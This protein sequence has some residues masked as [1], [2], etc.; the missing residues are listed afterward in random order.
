[1]LAFVSLLFQWVAYGK[2]ILFRLGWRLAARAPRPVVSI[3]NLSFGGTGKTPTVIA[4]CRALE[5][6]GLKAVVLTRGYRRQKSEETEQVPKAADATRYGDEPAL[7][8]ERI[9]SPVVV[10][11]KRARAALWAMR[12]SPDL[13]VLDDGFSHLQLARDL[14]VVLLAK[15]DMRSV[16][17]RR[18]LRRSLKDADFVCSL[19][20][21]VIDPPSGMLRIERKIARFTGGTPR[22]RI[23]AM[24]AIAHPERFAEDLAAAGFAPAQTRF[25]HDHHAFPAGALDEALRTSDSVV[26][27]EKDAVKLPAIPERVHVA[28]QE[29]I[30]PEELIDAVCALV[31][32]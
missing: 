25:F 3:G 19:E 14:N 31:K 28:I 9:D 16:A 26:I 15:D 11:A 21:A 13:F 22:G 27:T 32:K 8:A 1:M 30:I 12:L 2:R 24:C 6:R 5:R 4:L 20:P 18:E 10:D 7:I 17:R 29:V 23:T